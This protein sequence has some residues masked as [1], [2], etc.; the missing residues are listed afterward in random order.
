LAWRA[1]ARPERI[2]LD[3]DATLVSA[4][5]EK[6][7]AAGNWKGGFGFHPLLCFLD[8]SGEALAGLLRPGNAGSNTARDH[9]RVLVDALEQLPAEALD[10]EI[11]VRCDVGGATHDFARCCRDADIRF[12]VGYELTESVRAAI[13]QIPADA[14][15][16]AL[17]QDG[18][19]R[20]NGEV[21]EITDRVDLSAWP[22]GSLAP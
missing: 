12:A 8:G 22:S 1:G 21:A 3:I 9:E 19:V 13:L 2:V 11:L 4:H 16:R 18:S 14:W 17:D 7:D 10:E 5:S 20:E 15:V 6:E